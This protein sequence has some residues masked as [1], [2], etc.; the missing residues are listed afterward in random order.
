M[1]LRE[2]IDVLSSLFKALGEP[3]R[4]AI[5]NHLCQCSAQGNQHVNVN[6]VST[7]C[8]LDLSVVSRHLSTMKKAGVLKANKKG[9][10]VFYSLNSKDIATLLRELADYLETDCCKGDNHECKTNE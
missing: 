3:N 7:C 4:M 1:K 8:D 5:F 9:R 6:E 10:E 2:K